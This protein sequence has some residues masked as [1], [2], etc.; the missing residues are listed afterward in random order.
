MSPCSSA[1]VVANYDTIRLRDLYVLDALE[2][3]A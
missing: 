2:A 1:I 3:W